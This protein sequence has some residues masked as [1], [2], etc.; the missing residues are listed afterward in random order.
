MEF[1]YSAS[2]Q[3]NINSAPVVKPSTTNNNGRNCLAQSLI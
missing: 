3:L 1:R 2:L